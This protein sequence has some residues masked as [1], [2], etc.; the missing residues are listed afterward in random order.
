MSNNPTNC[1]I[2]HIRWSAVKE[3]QK[4]LSSKK[5]KII[6]FQIKLTVWPR[7]Y[8]LVEWPPVFLNNKHTKKKSFK[9]FFCFSRAL[10]IKLT[11]R[12]MY[13]NIESIDHGCSCCMIAPI[14]SIDWLTELFNC[15]HLFEFSNSENIMKE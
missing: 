5:I 6:S 3:P 12:I 1:A 9:V 13:W 11:N 14:I 2:R 4:M 15:M 10:K 7:T 8:D